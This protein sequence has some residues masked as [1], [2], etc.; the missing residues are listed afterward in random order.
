MKSNQS[1]MKKLILG[2]ILIVGV[3]LLLITGC[4]G[5]L[6]ET[7]QN[8]FFSVDYPE[9]WHI[10]EEQQRREEIGVLIAD[11]DTEEDFKETI[12]AV[13]ELNVEI[14]ESEFREGV[15]EKI[16]FMFA[17]ENI[18]EIEETEING[19]LAFK[20]NHSLEEDGKEYNLDIAFIY[21]DNRN[22]VLVYV[23][24]V[25]HYNEDLSQEIFESFIVN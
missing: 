23:G 19:N 11:A 9:S 7:Y 2:L 21:I 8:E 15:E 20:A 1:D 24:E 17:G 12:M 10:L 4:D 3:G 6:E 22:Y 25:E 16:N 13:K 5:G 18:G 14:S